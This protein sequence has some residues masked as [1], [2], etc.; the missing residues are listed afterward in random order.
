MDYSRFIRINDC[1]KTVKVLFFA[2]IL[3]SVLRLFNYKKNLI[4]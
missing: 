3:V 4:K 2:D 1:N